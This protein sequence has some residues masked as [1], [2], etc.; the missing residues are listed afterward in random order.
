MSDIADEPT[1]DG[2]PA[3]R[4]LAGALRRLRSGRGLA[5]DHVA[6]ALGW[7]TPK[8]S[9]YELAIR[10]PDDNDLQDLLA[11]YD[12]PPDQWPAYLA[13]A[14]QARTDSAGSRLG[15]RARTGHGGLRRPARCRAPRGPR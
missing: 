3:R 15:Q 6:K 5:Q 12:V 9:T 8:L 7:R 1:K 4:R 10:T 2:L 14:A 11:V 13:V